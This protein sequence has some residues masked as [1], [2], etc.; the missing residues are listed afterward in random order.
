MDLLIVFKQY[1]GAWIAAAAVLGLLIG[2]FLNVV[3][4]RLPKMMEQEWRSQCQEFL[5]SD[6]GS[7]LAPAADARAAS[8]FDLIFPASHCPK[9]K[10]RISP[11]DNIPVLSYLILR[12]K[13]RHCGVRITPRYPM[14]EAFT[15][16]LSAAVAW[17]FGF[18]W[19]AAAALFFTWALVVLTFIDFDTQLLPD[20]ITLPLVWA[21]LLLS[22]P[23][24]F[25]DS[26]SSIV[27]AATGYL[28]L[29]SIYHLFRI[30]TGKEGMGYGDFKLFA[31]FGA[32]MGWQS[33]PFI[34]LLSSLVGAVVGITLIVLQGRDKNVPIPFGPYLAGA[35]WIYL[36]WGDALT[37]GYYNQLGV[38]G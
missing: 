12:G 29:W 3:I 8:R 25:V 28:S 1:P 26:H 17:K 36:M 14:I 13:C 32:W 4:L 19:A 10:H 31:A 24:L 7:A 20:S 22:L 6:N 27:G 33:L 11:L 9:C 23:G 21:G 37:R 34:I 16:L 38:T 15:G 18:G 30:L 2:S 5:S 35:G